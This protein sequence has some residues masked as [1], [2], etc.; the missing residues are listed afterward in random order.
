MTVTR[1]EAEMTRPIERPPFDVVY[2]DLWPEMVRVARLATGSMA[3]AEEVAQDAFVGL[4]RHYD[5]VENPAGY[6]RRAVVNGARSR[7]RR[8]REH[9][10]LA[11]AHDQ[12]VH[13]RELDE[14]WQALRAL[15]PR[16]RMIV[17][18]RFYEDLP[19]SDIAETL[20]CSVGT[21]KST[22]ARSLVRLRKELS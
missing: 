5:T 13:D 10:S 16:Q 7:W 20:D 12:P 3:A 8:R 21:V 2:R 22:L 14:T 9:E 17:V 4:L 18:L 15:T 19:L 11:P 1:L 6:V